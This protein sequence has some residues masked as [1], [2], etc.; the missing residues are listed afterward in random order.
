MTSHPNPAVMARPPAAAD[1]ASVASAL[2]DV[3]ALG[4]YFM[5]DRD[6]T[7]ED[8]AGWVPA[9]VA[10]QRGMAELAAQTG[11]ALGTRE[12][13]VAVSTLQLGYAARLWSP[14]L[15]CAL[16]HGIVPDLA[17]LEVSTRLPL[18]VR[19]PSAAGWQAPDTD[20]AA[21][22]VYDVVVAGHLAPLA[23]GLRGQ[24]ASGLL[25]GN[26][27]SAMI[28][29][30]TVLADAR[31]GLAQPARSIADRLLAT[32]TLRGTGRLTGPGLAFRRNSCCLYY[33]VPDGGLCGD[34]SLHENEP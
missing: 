2:A 17:R 25:W 31:P 3:A 33:R 22:L 28:G 23:A 18:R 6:P 34:C 19:L 1:E 8:P 27:A 21:G 15:A 30:L 13:R 26:A 12:N 20:A 5:I 10:Y 29:S 16:A 24:V 7:E 14:A 11:Q 4:G 32:G 9:M